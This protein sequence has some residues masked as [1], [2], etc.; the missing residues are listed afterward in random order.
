MARLR[1]LLGWDY[2]LTLGVRRE[3]GQSTCAPEARP[4]EADELL[5][6]TMDRYASTLGS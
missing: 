1:V 6:D 2:P 5:E 4:H 3:P